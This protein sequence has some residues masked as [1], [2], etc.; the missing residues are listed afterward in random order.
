MPRKVLDAGT[1]L[2]D[3]APPSITG[4][5]EQVAELHKQVEQLQQQQAM[6]TVVL[7]HYRDSICYIYGAYRVGFHGQPPSLR[8]HIS[9]T[10]FVVAGGLIAT[11]RHV[12]EPWYRDPQ[13]DAVIRRGATPSLQRLIA[14]FP[15]S[16]TPVELAPAVIS[17]N[18][19][20]AVLRLEHSQLAEKLEPLPLATEPSPAG[21][22]VTV[23]GY[24]MGVAGMVAKSPTAIYERLAFGRDDIGAARELAVLSLI[25]PFATRGYLGDVVGN[26]LIYDVPTAHGGSGGPVFNSQGKV[27]AVNSAFIDGFSGGTVGISVQSLLPLIEAAD[28]Q[29]RVA[30]VSAEKEMFHQSYA[31]SSREPHMTR[32]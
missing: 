19:D 3:H 22:N 15:G 30:V 26:K 28:H 6:P 1:L 8:A 9:G 11:N 17:A 23:I 12:A 20:L 25:R 31:G 2:H 13:A 21:D 32:R 24:P 18:T 16:P 14:F 7:E 5:E 29:I 4:L 27:I 10:G